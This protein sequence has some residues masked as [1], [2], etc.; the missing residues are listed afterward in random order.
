MKMINAVPQ[1]VQKPTL[2]AGDVSATGT[3]FTRGNFR[4][5]PGAHDG[6]NI[7][8]SGAPPLLLVAAV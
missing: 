1:A 8:R 6:G 7:L 5:N 3:Q 4:R 2:Q